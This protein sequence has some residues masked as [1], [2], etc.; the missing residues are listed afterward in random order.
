ML[1]RPNSNP[2]PYPNPNPNQDRIEI[3]Q[4]KENAMML[5]IFG[6]GALLLLPAL[7]YY[8]FLR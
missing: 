5:R 1:L 6:V 2:N 4:Q 7:L 8:F 3:E